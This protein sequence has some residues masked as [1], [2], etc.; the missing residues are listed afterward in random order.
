MPFL[1]LNIKI[2][3]DLYKKLHDTCNICHIFKCETKQQQSICYNL[4]L[5]HTLK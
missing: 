4:A 1:Q 2:N 5:K 3:S